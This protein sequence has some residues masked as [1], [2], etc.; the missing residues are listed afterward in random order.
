MITIKVG[1]TPL[2]IPTDTALVLEQNNAALGEEGITAN[3]VWT[4]EI[5]A[6][7]NQRILG[8]V[9]YMSS[10]GNRRYECELSVDGVPFSRG[11]LYVQSATD[12]R[13]LSCGI[14]QR[15]RDFP[16]RRRPQA[17]LE[18]L[19]AGQSEKL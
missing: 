16:N 12:E 15:C 1:G 8:A 4:F 11:E 5:P 18:R 17:G 10:G 9:Q 13:R 3:V 6:E 19:S 7:P 2:Y 14:R